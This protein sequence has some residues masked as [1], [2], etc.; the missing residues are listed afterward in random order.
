VA[1]LAQLLEWLRRAAERVQPRV[2][3]VALPLPV[4]LLLAEAWPER[5][6]RRRK[7]PGPS[8]AT[9]DYLMANGRAVS[10]EAG[11]PL[12]RAEWIAV[13]DAGGAGASARVRLAAA[14]PEEALGGWLAGRTVVSESLSADPA[15]G[16]LGLVR[17][18][19]L[20]AIEVARRRAPASPEAVATAR[21]R[22]AR[23]PTPLLRT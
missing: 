7:V 14:I 8:D 10:L 9:A 20:G 12:A 2:V 15:S 19:R 4:G 21:A 1:L 18:E 22:E 3:L 16:R 5:V 11:D 23:Q 13:A 6:A 17:V